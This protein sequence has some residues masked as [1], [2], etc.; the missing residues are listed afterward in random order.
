MM[1]YDDYKGLSS[2]KKE[3]GFVSYDTE[4]DYYMGLLSD[5]TAKVGGHMGS[6]MENN[7]GVGKLKGLREAHLGMGAIPVVYG[8]TEAGTFKMAGYDGGLYIP[9]HDRIKAWGKLKAPTI[10]YDTSEF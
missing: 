8:V 2:D 4:Y 7:V 3:V 5:G 10:E 6:I 9:Y 1:E